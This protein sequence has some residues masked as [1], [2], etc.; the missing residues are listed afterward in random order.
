MAGVLGG[1]SAVAVIV[2][3]RSCVQL[4][5]LWRKE[6]AR[7]CGTAPTG[8]HNETPFFCL[9]KHFLL[10][11]FL[12]LPACNLADGGS[13]PALSPFLVFVVGAKVVAVLL[14]LHFNK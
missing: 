11:V 5:V 14:T 8:S 7:G 12:A 6:G 1:E 9:A 3:F 13:R 2:L 4:A 10:R